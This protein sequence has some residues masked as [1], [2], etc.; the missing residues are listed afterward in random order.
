MAITG[1]LC[2]IIE[3][4]PAIAR[5]LESHLFDTHETEVPDIFTN[6]EDAVKAIS[7]RDENGNYKKLYDFMI[8]DLK[9]P[10][11]LKGIDLLKYLTE[12]KIPGVVLVFSAFIPN[13]EID[14]LKYDSVEGLLT[15]G[16]IAK[17][18]DLRQI[19][20]IIRRLIREQEC[21]VQGKKIIKI[22]N[23]LISITQQIME[24]RE[25]TF[26]RKIT[27]SFIKKIDLKT[28]EIAVGIVVSFLMILIVGIWKQFN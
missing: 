27:N 28:E 19:S 18:S 10:G 11:K 7:E 15:V 21:K 23:Q 8:L 9:L 14:I 26:I 3:D 25:G 2:A 20:K 22:E 5:V 6:I 16:Y 12:H 17:P 13:N 1:K 24:M 4:D